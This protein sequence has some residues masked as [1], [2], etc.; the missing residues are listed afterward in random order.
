MNRSLIR[1]IPVGF[2]QRYALA[3]E[4][5]CDYGHAHI[6][7]QGSCFRSHLQV[8]KHLA[9]VMIAQ[10][11]LIKHYQSCA[12]E[13]R[14]SLG[15]ASIRFSGPSRDR[16]FKVRFCSRRVF[17]DA[18]FMINFTLHGAHQREACIPSILLN[19][20]GH[21]RGSDLADSLSAPTNND[22]FDFITL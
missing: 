17:V 12:E 5:Y 15:A 1:A 2:A 20:G 14:T 4:R 16:Y 10:Q 8:S 19:H 11:N 13:E 7:V 18:N 9:M 21:H 22:R 3:I 6:L